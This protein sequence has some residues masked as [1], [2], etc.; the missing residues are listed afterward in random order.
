MQLRYLL[1]PLATVI[2][3]LIG[4][5]YY[6]TSIQLDGTIVIP[7]GNRKEPIEIYHD[8]HAIP[9]I[10]AKSLGDAYY[11]LGWT[12]AQHR[13]WSM[14]VKKMLFSGRL[15]EMF[16]PGLLR[17]DKYMRTMGF[18]RTAH[19]DLSYLDG[20]SL[21]LTQ[22]YVDGINDYVDTLK[23][24]PTEF[25]ITQTRFE[26]WTVTDCLVFSKFMSW[27][28]THDWLT[29]LFRTR[30]AGV[31][32]KE[33]ACEILA[34]SSEYLYDNETTILN[35]EDL[36]A[37]GLYEPGV[38]RE[39]F[40]D[41]LEDNSSYTGPDKTAETYSEKSKKQKKE[42]TNKME[43][44]YFNMVS[45]LMHNMQGS[46]SWVISGNH[47][48]SG[49]PLLANDPHLDNSMPSIWMQAEL[50][51]GSDQ[52]IIGG[53]IPGLFNFGVGK[54]K[55]VTWGVTTPYADTAD[56]YEERLNRA[57]DK[58]YFDGSWH[59]LVRYH[60]PIKVKG[61]PDVQYI[62]N[63][64]RHGPLLTDVIDVFQK[65]LGAPFMLKANYSFAWTGHVHVDR[66]FNSLNSLIMAK[67]LEELQSIPNHVVNPVQ[68]V[69][70]TFVQGDIFYKAIGRLP[71][72]SNQYDGAFVL[73][74]TTTSTEWI[75]YAKNS[76][77]PQVVNPKKGFIIAA[78]NK[79]AT[80]N[81]KNNLSRTQAVTPRAA[82]IHE[83]I[84]S[85]INRGKKFTV[86][87][88][89]RIQLDT[90]DIYARDNVNKILKIVDRY[91]EEVLGG[92]NSSLE[93]VTQ[94]LNGWRGSFDPES[95]GATVFAVWEYLVNMKLF[96]DN[97]LNEEEQAALVSHM[98]YDQF[99]FRYIVKWW[100][101]QS[102]NETFC[103]NEENRNRTDKPCI[104]NIIHAMCETHNYLKN[105]LGPETAKWKWGA[106]HKQDY[107]HTPFS[108]SF[109]RLFYHR[110]RSSGGNRR[111]PNV[112][113]YLH[114]SHSFNSL[115]SAN[116]RMIASQA[117]EE[118]DYFVIDTGSFEGLLSGHYD[119]QLDLISRG[120]YLEMNFTSRDQLPKMKNKLV[121]TFAGKDGTKIEL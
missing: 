73:D 15:S 97:G 83:L 50:N 84:E 11:G 12:H 90:V 85:Q 45:D 25:L 29:Q 108:S 114:K 71:I 69:V 52:Q 78:N 66:S 36:Q 109:F 100:Q 51:W 21:E 22:A 106:L 39:P 38:P 33:R 49:R 68:N 34:C 46:N 115:S 35:D 60:E 98:Y 8:E 41:I 54:T 110:S 111:T 94:L 40:P 87:D 89:K 72:R 23:V 7:R 95:T 86:E 27:S 48:T 104:W 9:R 20:K 80:D 57:G 3:A 16:G 81:I 4:L 1:I 37:S 19:N 92:T 18:L 61:A 14:N 121:L 101:G 59:N 58:Y 10:F 17:I 79:F 13:L 62:V 67:S 99:F 77:N 91:K 116:F 55:Y 74:G 64:T 93:E 119:D 120:E 103:K 24:L 76:E 75:R 42:K 43:N 65:N 26:K 53:T 47:T 5:F 102:L 117:P 82:R 56:I 30:L 113:V 88:M 96:T 112:A 63:A 118:Q 28:L 2:P 105:L 6:L 44:F 70:G 32:G 31:F 107:S